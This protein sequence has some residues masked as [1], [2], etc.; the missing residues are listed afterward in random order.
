MPNLYSFVSRKSVAPTAESINNAE[1]VTS[2]ADFIETSRK[3]GEFV[4]D[5]TSEQAK[6]I[7]SVM[8]DAAKVV[9][10]T[11][12]GEDNKN[13]TQGLVT[14]GTNEIPFRCYG[15]KDEAVPKTEIVKPE[16]LAKLV[17]GVC[18]QDGNLKTE[19][20][21]TNGVCKKFAVPYLRI[22]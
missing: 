15:K 14:I 6:L 10:W 17:W 16:E 2:V 13:H 8:K 11:E 9:Y 18:F 22:A 21:H 7:K 4:F 5:E 3:M 20:K 19:T 12:K 1:L